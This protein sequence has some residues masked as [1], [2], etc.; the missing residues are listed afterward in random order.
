MGQGIPLE[1]NAA[2]L[3]AGIEHAGDGRLDALMGVTDD[4]LHPGEAAPHQVAQEARPE[5]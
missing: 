3:P 1:V 5:R 2:A 4:E